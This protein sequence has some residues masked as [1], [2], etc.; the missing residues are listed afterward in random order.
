MHIAQKNEALRRRKTL[1]IRIN[2]GKKEC[3]Q[4][5]RK[6]VFLDKTHKNNS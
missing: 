5:S 1:E 4:E 6:I 2:K 3:F